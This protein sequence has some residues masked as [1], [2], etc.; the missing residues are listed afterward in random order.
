MRSVNESDIVANIESARAK[1]QF[2]NWL[3][4]DEPRMEYMTA[5]HVMANQGVTPGWLR[6]L[7]QYSYQAGFRDAHI[8]TRPEAGQFLETEL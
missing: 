8:D 6:Y 5:L 3:N 2:N 1:R 4:K 7:M